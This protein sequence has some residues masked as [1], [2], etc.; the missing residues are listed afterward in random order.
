MAKKRPRWKCPVCGKSL[1]AVNKE[2]KITVWCT[3]CNH[4]L[5]YPVDAGSEESAL[6]LFYET[7]KR[8]EEK[9]QNK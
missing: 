6:D 5:T 3:G 9:C 2:Y 7:Y 8:D 4:R 1:G